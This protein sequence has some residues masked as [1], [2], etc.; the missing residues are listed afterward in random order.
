MADTG[1]AIKRH[2]PRSTESKLDSPRDLQAVLQ[3]DG[4]AGLVVIERGPFRARV[5]QL[6]LDHVRIAVV[7]ESLPRIAF[8][9]AHPNAVIALLRHSGGQTRPVRD[10]VI[11]EPDEIL[12]LGP[13]ERVHVRT[14]GPCGWSCIQFPL[15]GL[16][17]YAQLLSNKKLEFSS[18]KCW[19]PR[20]RRMGQLQSLR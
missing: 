11:E 12:V 17:R 4:L 14:E 1:V 18:V 6:V 13:G 15:P 8:F 3:P 16:T 7:Q 9:V 20:Y 10:G 5:T 19:K 2:M